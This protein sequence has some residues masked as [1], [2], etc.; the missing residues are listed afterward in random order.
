[1]NRFVREC[2]S[3][4]YAT[5]AAYD[6]AQ[7]LARI[8]ELNPDLV[9]TDLMMPR[10]SG[11]EMVAALRDKKDAI[12]VLVL[13]ARDEDQ[14][15]AELLRAGALDYV[16]KPFSIEELRARVR[17]LVIQKRA[18]D[19]LSRELKDQQ[20]DLDA[21][22]RQ[23]VGASTMKSN[24]L[25]IM[26]HELR[27]PIT[28][29]Q[30]QL[31]LFER[32]LEGESEHLS[33]I[34]RLHRSTRRLLEL[35]DSG[36][37]YARIE[38]G[39]FEL[40]RSE[41]SLGDLARDAVGEYAPQAEQKSVPIH[42]EAGVSIPPLTSDRDLV[43]LIALN[44]IGNA[45]KYTHQGEVEVRIGRSTGE[46]LLIVRDTGP[47]IP[48]ERQHEIFEPF[49]RLADI[50]RVAGA[51]SGLGLWLVSQMVRALGG[52]IGISSDS[53][54]GNTVIVAFPDTVLETQGTQEVVS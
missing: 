25:Q 43:R 26:A 41:F 54:R 15:R 22:A 14:L 35:V 36:L 19:V 21:L 10:M 29:I 18:R 34:D 5:A 28:A 9:I 4:D 33:L 50:R 13:S 44:L 31:T 46:Q 16:T 53:G 3:R 17:N 20:L 24:F 23:V 47:C 27:T 1:M 40:K 51:G 8:D 38:S 30:L 6:G 52:R 32:R 11:L 42:F 49:S 39:R 2:L 37:E 45:V 12:P 48:P 7:G